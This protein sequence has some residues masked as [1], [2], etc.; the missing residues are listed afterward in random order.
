MDWRQRTGIALT[1]R[2]KA[3][4]LAIS[5]HLSGQSI[6]KFDGASLCPGIPNPFEVDSKYDC[7]LHAHLANGN[8][9]P[10]SLSAYSVSSVVQKN[11]QPRNTRNTRKNSTEQEAMAHVPIEHCRLPSGFR[12]SFCRVVLSLRLLVT[13]DKRRGVTGLTD[14]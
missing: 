9:D 7:F 1:A 11:P 2:P 12:N 4:A 6:A 14:S 10:L 13:L 5:L 8:V 3:T